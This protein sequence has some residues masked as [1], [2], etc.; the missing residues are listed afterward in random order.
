MLTDDREE[1]ERVADNLAKAANGEKTGTVVRAAVGVVAHALA[2][3]SYDRSKED[4]ESD[5]AFISTMIR[6]IA[7]DTRN[8][9]IE[10]EKNG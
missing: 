7:T 10:K 5:C 4:F 3:M 1:I 2:T 8:R 6:I 9:L